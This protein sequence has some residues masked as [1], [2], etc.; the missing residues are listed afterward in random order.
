MKKWGD[1]IR[2]LT[3]LSQFAQTVFH[4]SGFQYM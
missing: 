2:N 3:M 1:I 4:E